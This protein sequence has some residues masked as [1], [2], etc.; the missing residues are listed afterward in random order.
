M[1]PA[2][3]FGPTEVFVEAP[4]LEQPSPPNPTVPTAMG[5]YVRRAEDPDQSHGPFTDQELNAALSRGEVKKQD[6]VWC[7]RF[8]EWTPVHQIVRLGHSPRLLAQDTFPLAVLMALIV[9]FTTYFLTTRTTTTMA[10]RSMVSLP[11]P[12]M[13]SGQDT[14]DLRICNFSD[15]ERIYVTVAYFDTRLEDWVARGWYPQQRGECK[16]ALKNLPQPVYVFA[17][18]RTGYSRWSSKDKDQADDTRFCIDGD[19]AFI[20]YQGDCAKNIDASRVQSFMRLP[21]TSKNPLYTW[22]IR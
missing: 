16:T 15:E 7:Q 22:E 9:C 6:L 5:W 18:T 1:G 13:I 2:Y 14:V 20:N 17:E 12:N 8:P 11:T 3:F 19:K 21:I 10:A 4:D